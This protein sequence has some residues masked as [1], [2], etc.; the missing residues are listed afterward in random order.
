M[1]GQTAFLELLAGCAVPAVNEQ[2]FGGR[3]P[4][5]SRYAV[6]LVGLLHTALSVVVAVL[7]RNCANQRLSTANL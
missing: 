1:S 5:L 7:T 6:L 2:R 4:L 3:R